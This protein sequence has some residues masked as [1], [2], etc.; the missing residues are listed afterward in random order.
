MKITVRQ[1]EI[2]KHRNEAIVV[3]LFEGVRPGGATAAVDKA[4]GGLIGAAVDCG[5]FTGAQN[6]T[7]LLYS[8]GRIPTPSALLA[9]QGFLTKARQ[10][11]RQRQGDRLID[12][13]NTDE[14]LLRTDHGL[15]AFSMFSCRTSAS[16]SVHY[17]TLLGRRDTWLAEQFAVAKVVG[18][19]VSE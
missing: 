13:R 4:L 14:R 10:R 15:P 2:Q 9:V 17:T 6:D 16:A 7:R 8:Q 19:V 5:D 1:G 3:N 12:T 11:L 18:S